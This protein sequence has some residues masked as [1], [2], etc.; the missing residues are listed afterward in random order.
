MADD[1]PD[2]PGMQG[3]LHWQILVGIE[4][5]T[6]LYKSAVCTHTMG[7]DTLPSIEP[8]IW[9]FTQADSKISAVA[10]LPGWRVEAVWADT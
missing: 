3:A 4:V 8:G 9:S 7:F 1:Q 6:R 2:V 5:H 10:A